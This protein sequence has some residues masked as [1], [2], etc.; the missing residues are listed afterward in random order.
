[1]SL[2]LASRR[3]G[4]FGTNALVAGRHHR[5]ADERLKE[6]AISYVKKCISF[7]DSI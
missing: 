3:N 5:L 7:A 2:R 6:N 1:M 4:A